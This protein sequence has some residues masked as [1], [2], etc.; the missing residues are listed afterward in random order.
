MV[1]KRKLKKILRTHASYPHLVGQELWL[2]PVSC[3]K[4]WWSEFNIQLLFPSKRVSSTP[5]SMCWGP[6]S[7]FGPLH[8]LT[9]QQNLK[10]TQCLKL[11]WNNLKDLNYFIMQNNLF[12]FSLYFSHEIT[13]PSL[14][15]LC[16]RMTFSPWSEFCTFPECRSSWSSSFFFLFKYQFPFQ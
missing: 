11:P 9:H 15:D 7:P 16:Q 8:S 2:P 3:S 13:E 5:L 4:H 10:A 14:A 12:P 1:L 6:S